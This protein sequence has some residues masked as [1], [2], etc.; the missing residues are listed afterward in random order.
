[1]PQIDVDS[2][3]FTFPEQWV[4]SKYDDWD[5]FKNHFSKLHSGIKGVDIIAVDPEETV[6]LIEAK[7]YRKSCET[8]DSNFVETIWKKVFGTLAAL[9]PAKVN[10]T[11]VDE[12]TLATRALGAKGLRIVLQYE[13]PNSSS[14][15]FQRSLSIADI[16]QKFKSRFKAI[17]PHALVVSKERMPQSIEW[18]VL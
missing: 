17:D 8:V 7:D 10:A 15:L 2:L 3:K 4:V 11:S 6:W 12:K 5:F 13:P 18:S 1:M 16:Q 14:S 9:L